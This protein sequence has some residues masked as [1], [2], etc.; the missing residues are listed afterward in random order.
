MIWSS[1]LEIKDEF[2]FNLSPIDS[3]K[4]WEDLMD[5]LWINAEKFAHLIELLPDHKLDDDFVNSKY[6]T[7]Q[8]NLDGMIE[9]CYYHLG[10]ISL[11]KKLIIDQNQHS[12][13]KL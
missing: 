4:T 11:I 13:I 12:Y 2:S 10:Q 9:H 7:Y 6:G 5:N 8:R 1:L 3:Q